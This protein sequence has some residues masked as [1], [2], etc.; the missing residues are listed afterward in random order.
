MS[1]GERQ[2][3][4]LALVGILLL[5]LGM[6]TATGSFAPVFGFIDAEL[7]VGTLVLGVV[8][9]LPLIG[10]AT[11]GFVAPRVARAVGL[12]RALLLA[13]GAAVCPKARVRHEIRDAR[14]TMLNSIA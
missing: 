4:V 12:E 14:L 7:H 10:F 5:A 11:A 3:K 8:G 9:A 6:R 13:V 2:G 1:L